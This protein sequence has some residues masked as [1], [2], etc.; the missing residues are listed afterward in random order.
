[1]NE[2]QP[3]KVIV[4]VSLNTLIKIV[5]V[6]LA[7][8]LLYLVRNIL[9]I[10]LVVIVISVALEP[11]VA[12]LAK[13]GVPRA[14]SVIVL[15]IAILAVLS[16]AI[17]FIVPPVAGQITQLAN[18]IPYYSGKISELDFG[19]ATESIGKILD[20]IASQASVLT[21]GIV[22]ALVSIFGGVFST[23][24]I[25]ALTYYALVAEGG[26]E[27]TFA[28]FIPAKS[29]DKMLATIRKVS[30]KLGQWLRGQLTLML[31][32]GTLD[33]VALWAIG[34]PFALTLGITAGLLEVVPIIGPI[35]S[36]AIAVFIGLVS[37]LSLW[38][39]FAIV[40]AFI[41]VQQIE[42]QILIPKIM[43]KA[44]GLSPVIVIVAILL[45]M[46]LLGIGGAV[47]ALPVAAIIQVFVNEY[48]TNRT[49]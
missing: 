28:L 35:M 30:A 23:I 38:K 10:I 9:I 32:V 27:N 7:I 41:L 36:G 13:Q 43:Q 1:M 25:F 2:N 16:L 6:A 17:Y 12:R 20:Q 47:L 22:G 8:G 19:I 46:E 5:L 26:V 24:T 3:R 15:Y 4:D 39:I 33:G 48:S 37:G 44:I 18:E 11:I 45:G 31:I 21:G 40:I 42:N 14:L 34:V 29:K 49:G